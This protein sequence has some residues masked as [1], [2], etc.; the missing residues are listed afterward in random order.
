MF[1]KGPWAIPASKI[2][3]VENH[4][5]VKAKSQDNP[6]VVLL[7]GKNK[8]ERET[9]DRCIE[10]VWSYS[11]CVPCRALAG[12]PC[13]PP[14]PNVEKNQG[15]CIDRIRSYVT[16]LRS[17]TKEAT[18]L[19]AW[20]DREFSFDG[21]IHNEIIAKDIVEDF[22]DGFDGDEQEEYE[23]SQKVGNIARIVRLGR[24]NESSVPDHLLNLVV[25]ANSMLIQIGFSPKESKKW[26]VSLIETLH[27]GIHEETEEPEQT[28]EHNKES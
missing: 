25:A 14:G 24:K 7:E 5:G 1:T 28:G 21:S 16:K 18:W 3:Q 4:L 6:E 26:L 9:L 13:V 27:R 2:R 22:V 19:E 10:A 23:Y 20:L 12:Y 11:P 17:Y 15:A 8:A